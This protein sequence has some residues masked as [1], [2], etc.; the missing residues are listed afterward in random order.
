MV[1]LILKDFEK[2]DQQIHLNIQL[3]TLNIKYKQE[4]QLY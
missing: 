2:E 4:D 3:Q 1:I